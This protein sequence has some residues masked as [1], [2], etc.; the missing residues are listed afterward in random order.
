[1]VTL[2]I[3]FSVV[4]AHIESNNVDVARII[5]NVTSCGR[6]KWHDPKLGRRHVLL[7]RIKVGPPI[8]I[9]VNL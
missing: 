8:L 9:Y 3:I 2:H 6:P 1:M 4:L 5:V 7:C